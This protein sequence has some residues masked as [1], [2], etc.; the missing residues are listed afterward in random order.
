MKFKES[1]ELRKIGNENVLVPLDNSEINM[2]RII[3]LNESALLVYD[4]LKDKDFNEQD[5]CTL[6]LSNYEVSYT[7]AFD[8]S[9]KLIESFVRAGLLDC[10]I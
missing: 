3:S 8:D 6:L 9:K 10:S 7:I 2:G 4:A 5:I 1:L